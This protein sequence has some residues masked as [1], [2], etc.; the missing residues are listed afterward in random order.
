M[1][2]L[3]ADANG[4]TAHTNDSGCGAPFLGCAVSYRRSPPVSARRLPE[5]R[6]GSFEVSTRRASRSRRRYTAH[7]HSLADLLDHLLIEGRN[8]VRL[9]ARHEPFVHDHF[10]VDPIT[11]GVADVGLQ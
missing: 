3:K 6:S 2:P 10:A 11:A 9:A 5:T 1:R 8:V 4:A 7:V